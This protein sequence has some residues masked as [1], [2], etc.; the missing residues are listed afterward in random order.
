[1]FSI[2]PWGDLVGWPRVSVGE[3]QPMM[4]PRDGASLYCTWSY[5]ESLPP[6]LRAQFRDLDFFVRD[7]CSS[8][9]SSLILVAPYLSGP[10]MA[11]LRGPIAA[12]AQRGTWIRLVTSGLDDAEGQNR[13]ALRILIEGDEGTVVKKRLRVLSATPAL[14]HLIHAKIVLCDESCG[15]L[16]S[17][18]FSLSAMEKNF[19]VGVSL[20]LPQAKSLASL[21]AVFEAQGLFC[22]RTN[23]A[24]ANS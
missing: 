16:G 8:A 24:L 19:E 13:S 1:M 5:R 4:A 10:G 7:L 22:D 9:T 18:N 2:H 20:A 6:A 21:V 17:A 23:E 11:A 12:S 3:N 15:Y 14:P